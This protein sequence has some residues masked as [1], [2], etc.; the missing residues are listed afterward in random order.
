MRSKFES[1][2]TNILDEK[3]RL[4]INYN[5]FDDRIHFSFHDSRESVAEYQMSSHFFLKFLSLSIEDFDNNELEILK[6]PKNSLLSDAVEIT[7]D[8]FLRGPV[9][10]IRYERDGTF[11]KRKFNFISNSKPNKKN[12]P[13]LL[14][15]DII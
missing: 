12:N 4:Y 13:Y 5:E 2:T 6:L 1:R 8:S 9:R 11:Y 10:L 15:G 7:S 14:N 3:D